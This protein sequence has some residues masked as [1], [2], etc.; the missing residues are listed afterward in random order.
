MQFNILQKLSK[1]SDKALEEYL[2]KQPF[3]D[4]SLIKKELDDIYYNDEKF[5]SPFTDSQYDLLKEIIQSKDKSFKD[6]VGS[7]IREDDNRVKLPY[8]LGSIDKIK[9]TEDNKLQ[10]WLKK[11][12]CD[13]YIVQAKLD[14]CSCLLVKSMGVVKI[15][16]RGDGDYGADI[17]HLLEYIKNIPTN[18]KDDISIRGELIIKNQ[19]FKEKYSKDVSNPRN[20]ISGLLN[21]KSLKK[22]VTDIDFV[23]Y[24]IIKDIDGLQDNIYRQFD[25][26]SKLGFKVV[27][28]KIE[29]ELTMENLSENLLFQKQFSEYDIDGIVIYPDIEYKRN[30]DK[31]PKYAFAFKMQLDSNLIEAEVEKVIWNISKFKL[32]KPRIK[33]KPVNLNGVTINYTSGFNAKY[34][35]DKNI[36]PGALIKLTRSGD[37]IPYIVDIIKSAEYPDIPVMP[38]KWNENRVDIIALE[39]CNNESEIKLI[40]SF[41][42]G[43]GIKFVNEKTVE[44]FYNSGYTSI[45]KILEA[46]VEDFENIDGFKKTLAEKV[47]NNIH[48]GLQNI[49]LYDLLGSSGVFEGFGSRKI[50]TLLEAIPNI[51]EI[52]T[53][54]KEDEF[55][56]KICNIE[57]FSEKSSL[58]IVK[59][60]NL[61]IDLLEASRG[62]PY[63][64]STIFIAAD[65]KTVF[66]RFTWA[67]FNST[68][69]SIDP[70][71]ESADA[72]LKISQKQLIIKKVCE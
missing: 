49:K 30:V 60:L 63:V 71:F 29:K 57:G 26:L 31:N 40:S 19:V 28:H 52:Y 1:L 56:K 59:S 51:F 69:L 27:K 18:L 4:L 16:T 34:I 55:L 21:S 14:G 45:L 7:Q 5:E 25:K 2:N 43:M 39:D 36:G 72:I 22:G 37:V 67:H 10:N 38:F 42:K 8:Y 58:K 41:F 64:L 3:K 32:I 15:Y 9:F 53:T 65:P 12:I 50:K 13:Q 6:S 66:S 35:F 68:L 11:N 44:K 48:N 17:S 61:S 62:P 23:A 33:I 47:Y 20:M 70:I 24:E 54:I 46:S